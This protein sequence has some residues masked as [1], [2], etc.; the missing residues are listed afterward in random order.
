MKGPDRSN[1]SDAHQPEPDAQQLP[2]MSQTHRLWTL[3][4]DSFSAGSWRRWFQ[5]SR[6]DVLYQ[7]GLGRNAVQVRRQR[8]R[9]RLQPHSSSALSA[10]HTRDRNDPTQVAA[11]RR[12]LS[13]RLGRNDKQRGRGNPSTSPLQLPATSSFLLDM[14]VQ[15]LPRVLKQWCSV[16]LSHRLFLAFLPSDAGSH[17]C[18][19]DNGG[20]LQLLRSLT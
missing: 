5:V 19:P 7:I 1:E 15:S 9:A 3:I 13:L 6:L 12:H 18:V 20:N 4:R 11:H 10:H 17:S 2:H 14:A 8:D 16:P